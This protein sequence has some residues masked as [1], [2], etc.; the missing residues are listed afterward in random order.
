M[1]WNLLCAFVKELSAP[2][3]AVDSVLLKTTLGLKLL[4]GAGLITDEKIHERKTKKIL[5]GLVYKQQKYNL[6]REETEGY[7]KLAVVLCSIPSYPED[8]SQCVRQVLS[9]IGRFELDP[10]RALDV[11]LDVFE[12]QI[13]N[14]SFL[15]LLKLFSRNNIPHI[16]GFK[17]TF[18]H[19]AIVEKEVEDLVNETTVNAAAAD[20]QITNGKLSGKAKDLGVTIPKMGISNIAPTLTIPKTISN[21]NPATTTPAAAVTA[22][23]TSSTATATSVPDL[24]ASSTPASLYALTALLL[25]ADLV[26]IKELL[27]YLQPSLEETASV[28][29]AIESALVKSIRSH[30]QVNLA[31]LDSTGPVLGSA[32]LGLTMGMGMGGSGSQQ[33]M[34][35]P[36]MPFSLQGQGIGQVSNGYAVTPIGAFGLPIAPGL[37][38]FPV[39]ATPFG[40]NRRFAPGLELKGKELNK[41]INTGSIFGMDVK[42]KKVLELKEP[43]PSVPEVLFAD[44]NQIIG[45]ISAL[46][47]VR[48]WS[49]A[50]SLILLLENQSTFD[51]NSNSNISGIDVMR[52]ESIREALCEF[53]LWSTET[54]YKPYSISKLKLSLKDKKG[55]KIRNAMKSPGI[56]RLL[57]ENKSGISLFKNHQMTQYSNLRTFVSD[58]TPLL[59]V[60]RHHVSTDTA[61]YIRLCRLLEAHIKLVAPVSSSEKSTGVK[62]VKNE[63]ENVLKEDE[64]ILLPTIEILS[65]VLLPSLTVSKSNPTFSRQLWRVLMLLPF[66]IRYSLYDN[67]RGEGLGKDGLGY[68][69]SQV[70]MAETIALNGAK[71]LFKRLAKENV[72]TIG[73]QLNYFSELAPVAVYYHVSP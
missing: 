48:C 27:P 65:N 30:G 34:P 17:F 9:L 19:T 71:Y 59:L 70:V 31:S 47:S 24:H 15:Q 56:D 46:L 21:N 37:G 12:Q 10:N 13:W 7:S 62:V 54:I 25:A 8:V 68:K 22:T 18:Y 39:P 44:G 51:T 5:T 1:A 72:A 29:I 14:L 55:H 49:L 60:A 53:L 4:A 35:A 32:G 33:N 2:P 63:K 67:W 61:L 58:I 66:Q 16:L 38:S 20:K 69:N 64:L 23:S 6:L 28:S 57:K 41:D 43:E 36:P 3:S 45:L 52:F 11:I 73:A 50:H 26:T 40:V 42:G